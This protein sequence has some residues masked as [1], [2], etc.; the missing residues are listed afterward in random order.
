MKANILNNIFL[1]LI[2]L[3]LTTA[4]RT[5]RIVSN[6]GTVAIEKK[7]KY[8]LSDI[9]KKEFSFETL[10][11]KAKANVDI[12]GKSQDLSLNIRIK[13]G[14]II[15]LSVTAF[16]GVEVARLYVTPDS[17]KLI[18]RINSEYAL[19]PF[20]F[21]HQY[22]SSAISYQELEALLTG[23][24]LPFSLLTGSSKITEESNFFYLAGYDKNL[25]FKQQFNEVLQLLQLEL[26]DTQTNQKLEASYQDY[27]P[28]AGKD[29]PYQIRLSSTLE[30]QKVSLN[31]SYQSIQLQVQQDYPFNIPK[32][33]TLI[34]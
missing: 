16:A 31:L 7:A 24:A 5:K 29:F 23:N 21:I 2:A 14:Q 25:S 13:K 28:L 33:Y 27:K 18:N 15:W 3:F 9:K 19:K 6:T 8:N 32:R 26:K 30:N 1:V 12:A 20:E 22:A 17:V 34:E 11:A 10:A 4:C